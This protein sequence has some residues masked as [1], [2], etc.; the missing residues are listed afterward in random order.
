MRSR[1]QS[2]GQMDMFVVI[3]LKRRNQSLKKKK[4][5]VVAPYPETHQKGLLSIEKMPNNKVYSFV[6]FGIQIADDGRVWIC[7]DGEAFIRFKPYS[8]N[9][10][11]K[12]KHEK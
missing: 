1:E 2:D 9:A 3:G 6:D 10:Q 8:A 12:V 4:P 11:I 7:V 5:G